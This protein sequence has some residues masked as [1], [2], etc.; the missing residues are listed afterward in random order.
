[1]SN[2]ENWIGNIIL[3]NKDGIYDNEGVKVLDLI[4]CSGQ[5]YD[6]IHP[7]LAPKL[8]AGEYSLGLSGST[9]D[10]SGTILAGDNFYGSMAWDGSNFWIFDDDNLYY[11][12][13]SYTVSRFSSTWVY[14]DYYFSALDYNE[15]GQLLSSGGQGLC[16]DG[17]FIYV[18]DGGEATLKKYSKSGV[19]TSKSIA[20][21]G[22]SINPIDIAF[23]GTYIWVNDTYNTSKLY[24]FD[25]E[26]VYLNEYIDIGSTEAFFI[27]YFDGS[28]IYKKQYSQSAVGADKVIYRFNSETQET[29]VLGTLDLPNET[30]TEG[31][32]ND[33]EYIYILGSTT[34][35]VYKGNVSTKVYFPSMVSPTE[36]VGY[37][38]IGD[39]TI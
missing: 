12:E 3:S 38:I 19:L 4:P 7:K 15:E 37:K 17:D 25:T 36:A 10:V 31:L 27:D 28:F 16:S 9:Y 34:G 30:R 26:L 29:E 1:M 23:D 24:K 6:N 39:L 5:E 20:L 22:E 33:G 14:E 2:V 21:W 13:D 18:V 8:P 32:C 11:P 35:T